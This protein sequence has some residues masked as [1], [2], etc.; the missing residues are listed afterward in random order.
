MTPKVATLYFFILLVSFLESWNV[1]TNFIEINLKFK[2][3]R[4]IAFSKY[5]KIYGVYL[6]VF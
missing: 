3:E 1:S 2:N 5:P 4:W 6:N